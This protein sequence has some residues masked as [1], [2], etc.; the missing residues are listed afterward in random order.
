MITERMDGFTLT[1]NDS[2][3]AKNRIFDEVVNWCKKYR[4][5][6]GESIM[7]RDDPQI[8]APVL[9]ARLADEI[10]KFDQHWDDED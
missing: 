7:Q 1:Y 6:S 4:S 8:F 2:Q 10:L 3:E 9:I 5:Y